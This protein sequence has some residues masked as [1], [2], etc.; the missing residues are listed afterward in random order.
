MNRK[1]IYNFIVSNESFTFN[2]NKGYWTNYQTLNKML[3]YLNKD[4]NEDDYLI[5]FYEFL[6]VPF[7]FSF[8][9]WLFLLKKD[10][11]VV[12][13]C[14]FFE[15]WKKS[16]TTFLADNKDLFLFFLNDFVENASF[17]VKDVLRVY[18]YYKTFY[19]DLF[20]F[21]DSI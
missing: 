4:S 11:P 2:S 13:P 18:F 1:I 12:F 10:C 14:E 8:D 20:N 7:F 19:L 5:P 6:N 15:K 17:K 16:S 9:L 21:Y 3:L